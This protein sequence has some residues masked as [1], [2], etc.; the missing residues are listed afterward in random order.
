M[1]KTSVMG[2]TRCRICRFEMR[3]VQAAKEAAVQA[4]RQLSALRSRPWLCRRRKPHAAVPR[5]STNNLPPRGNHSD[6]VRRLR[7]YRFLQ[8]R[9]M[10]QGRRCRRGLRTHVWG[11]RGDCIGR[12]H[13]QV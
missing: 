11:R 12:V 3:T 10:G 8:R 9:P 6:A 5:P 4:R 13:V 7:A 2:V 1:V